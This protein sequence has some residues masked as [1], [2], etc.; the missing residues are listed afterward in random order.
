MK[1]VKI[2][3]VLFILSLTFTSC[4]DYGKKAVKDSIEVYYKDGVTADQAQKTAELLAA[5]VKTK[6]TRSIQLIKKNDVYCYRMVTDK[7]K[8]ASSGMPDE[9]FFQI[10]NEISEN[11]FNGAPVN[12]ELTD[13]RFETFKTFPYKKM[14]PVQE[15][16]PQ[17]T[18]VPVDNN[19]KIQEDTTHIQQ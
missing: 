14:A 16:M 11:I 9:T 19:M 13:D 2:L 5:S 1:M 3:S 10:G 7:A 4:K 18:D 12:V 15:V 6:D 17:P 8:L